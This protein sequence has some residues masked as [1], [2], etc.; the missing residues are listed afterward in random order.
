VR[1]GH[2]GRH[3]RPSRWAVPVPRDEDLGLG[4]GAHRRGAKHSV[5]E[6]RRNKP[7]SR[8]G[9]GVLLCVGLLAAGGATASLIGNTGRGAG[10]EVAAADTVRYGDVADTLVS[11][12]SPNKHYGANV[13]LSASD[14]PGAKK[15]SYLRFAIPSAIAGEITDAQLVLTRDAHHLSGDVM[16][17]S[18]ASEKWS[19]A[20]I[21]A[22]QAPI[23][24]RHIGTVATSRDTMTVSFDVT[25]VATAH[26]DAS[27]ALTSSSTT[28]VARFNSREASHGRPELLVTLNGSGGGSPTG[29]PTD[30]PTDGPTGAPS[31]PVSSGAPSTPGGSSH[32]SSTH[33]PPPPRSSTPAP[34]NSTTPGGGGSSTT[35]PPGSLVRPNCTI[36]ADLV[37]ACGR[38]WGMA[39]RAWTGMPVQQAV[40]EDEANFDQPF[41]I[42]HRYHV[43]DQLFPTAAERAVALQPGHNRLLFEN[44]KPATDMTWAAVAKGGADSRIDAEAA[45]IKANFNY[46]F[47]L[48]IWHE[49]ENDVNPAAGSGNTATDYAAM[50]QHVVA[51]LRADGCN[52]VVTVMTYMNYLP[53][54]EKSWWPQLWPGAGSVDWIAVDTYVSAAPNEY[55]SGDFNTLMNRS[56]GGFPGFYNWVTANLPNLP[57]MIGEWGVFE[58]TADPGR[59]ADVYNSVANDIGNY[60]RIKA[61][62]YFDMPK[63]PNDQG[64]D[65]APNQSASALAA[66]NALRDNPAFVSPAIVY[67]PGGTIPDS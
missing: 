8:T 13:R 26:P 50:F 65:T 67:G 9:F 14:E 52:K 7:V 22:D 25:S 56:G 59:T 37:P 21:N 57:I 23:M 28:D 45:Y 60:P 40:T 16:L 58:D 12:Q 29:A 18:V 4:N 31:Q 64:G 1:V 63:P 55:N 41:D 36:S 49:P 61:L 42:V 30:G 24:G 33:A 11:Y 66:F 19:Q 51:R 5:P 20:R 6:P 27:F 34:G 44:W 48:T 10:A 17:S 54:E 35:S 3:V 46:P 2:S 43:N 15:V 32:S 53:W 39:P 38:L 62:V 47:F